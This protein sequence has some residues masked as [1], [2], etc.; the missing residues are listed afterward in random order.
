[1]SKRSKK[2]WFGFP[3]G[4]STSEP[5]PW[6]AILLVVSMFFFTGFTFLFQEYGSY[7]TGSI[8]GQKTT[9]L[10][11]YSCPT[12]GAAFEVSPIPDLFSYQKGN[13]DFNRRELLRINK[14]NQGITA[15]FSYDKG[16]QEATKAQLI[17]LIAYET[18]PT[19]YAAKL[20]EKIKSDKSPHGAVDFVTKWFSPENP[21]L[22]TVY[23]YANGYVVEVK[24]SSSG[25]GK[26]VMICTDVTTSSG[27]LRILYSVAHLDSIAV[28]TGQTITAGTVLGNIGSTGS[29]TTP[30]A[31]ITIQPDLY[32]MS[33]YKTVYNAGYNFYYSTNAEEILVKQID[34]ISVILNP[35]I[36]YSIVTN[37]SMRQ[38][39]FANASQ[40]V[41]TSL[42]LVATNSGPVLDASGAQI[43][44]LSPRFSSFRV[45]SS[46]GRL[47]IGQST[48]V[49]VEA[50]D[51]NN[52]LFT[53]FNSNVDVV[54]SSPTA[55]F[56]GVKTMSS[57]KTSFQV[58]DTVP[59]EVIVTVNN[60]GSI[61][62]ETKVVFTD[63]LK[64][65]EVTAPQKTNVGKQVVVSIKPIGTLG[66]VISDP[67]TVQVKSFP[68]LGGASVAA[69]NAGRG[70]YLFSAADEGIYQ[71]TFSADQVQESITIAVQKTEG[72]PVEAP[73]QEDPIVPDNSNTEDPKPETP[74]VVEEP[75]TDEVVTSEPEKTEET[76]TDPVVKPVDT[77]ID[78][79][80]Q[81]AA[82]SEITL[83]EGS[84]YRMY[85]TSEGVLMVY[86]DKNISGEYP[87]E[88]KF[89]V[90]ATTNAVSIF[91][92]INSRAFPDSGELKLTKYQP[93]QEV[94]R[95]YP[96]HVGEESYKK[97]VAYDVNGQVISE[98]VF[99]WSPGSLHLFT[100]V[101]DGVTDQQI[102]DAVEALKE[103]GVVKGN[104]DGS[105]GVDT[106]IN[107]A[108][109]ATLLIRAF[110][111]DIDLNTFKVEKNPFPDVK[112]DAWYASAISFASLEEYQGLVKPVIIKGRPDGKA[113]PDGNVKIEEFLT[114]VLRVLEVDLQT[115]TPWYE[116]AIAK[117][118]ELG[119]ITE[120][121]RSFI[122]QPLSR[123]MVARILVAAL[124]KAEELMPDVVFTDPS[125]S[126]AEV[127]TSDM[128]EST[129]VSEAA[130]LAPLS[131]FNTGKVDAGV[132]LNWYNN[133][134]GPF[135][136]SRETVGSSSGEISIG[137]SQSAT[138][139][140]V[141]AEAGKSYVYRIKVNDAQGKEFV[142]ENRIDL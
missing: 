48:D 139:V 130:P 125:H 30:H 39:I 124:E 34:P 66:G 103:A 127:S 85:S 7:L 22:P 122:D 2:S 128:S 126:A 140:D 8:V 1:M 92:G 104:P 4:S 40:F 93:G 27:S 76:K 113:D 79:S 14:K 83:L 108:A 116:S 88:T 16:F 31:H 51:Q 96:K 123:G 134:P 29:S 105:Y 82:P 33:N 32:W 136:I 70:E 59:G 118:I 15:W 131:N 109:T 10:G 110:Y 12:S 72:T 62:A 97:I 94:V 95:Y 65:L 53:S 18:N 135:S 43:L 36:A 41:A 25:Y 64:Y 141:S 132:V 57:G 74:V 112:K 5:L 117:S 90:P 142:L 87:I 9:L 73:I 89:T 114:M 13:L 11:S 102:Y 119:L 133:V 47:P 69:L 98:L 68:D 121:E 24:E 107:R 17:D 80:H 54:L 115:S 26:H 75:K 78:S 99:I 86:N 3:K 138:F 20:Y 50:L 84:G 61:S 101:I 38:E 44:D 58:K 81:A 63:V 56:G 42:G 60:Q 111:T 91:T 19:Q 55:S 71:L 120:K 23:P 129:N 77:A 52:N 35:S 21:N 100:D 28:Q 37:D 67:V 46:V 6:M 106:P 45:S 49:T 137:A